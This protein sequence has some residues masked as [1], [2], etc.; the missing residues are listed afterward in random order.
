[1]AVNTLYGLLR[2]VFDDV[3]DLKMHP[4]VSELALVLEQGSDVEL[5][6]IALA[7][8]REF[9]REELSP[10]FAR[11]STHLDDLDAQALLPDALRTS[12]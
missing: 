1:M 11:L 2:S 12:T 3:R 4:L 10:A 6:E 5:A 8:D 9:A 7:L